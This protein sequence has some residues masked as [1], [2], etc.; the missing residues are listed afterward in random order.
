MEIVGFGRVMGALAF[1]LALFFLCIA[2]LKRYRNPFT[3]QSPGAIKLVDQLTI[4]IG[5]RAILIEVDGK[6]SLVV[7]SK[8]NAEHIWTVDCPKS[9]ETML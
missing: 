3:I 7:L 9:N 2:L 6:R 4:D 1:V 8:E 5:R